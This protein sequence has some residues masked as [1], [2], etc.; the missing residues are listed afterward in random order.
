M[1][2]NFQTRNFESAPGVG[3]ALNSEPGTPNSVYP[4]LP[5]NTESRV[6]ASVDRTE[7]DNMK[8][9]LLILGMSAVFLIGVSFSVRAQ[10]IDT[11]DANIP[12]SF[13]V[14]NTTVPAGTYT[15]TRL[16]SA[17]NVMLIRDQEGHAAAIFLA[18]D[19]VVTKE[20]RETE[21]IFNRIGD[22]YFLSKIFE[23]GSKTGV[24][25]PKPR[26]ERDLEKEALTVRVESVSVH[27]AL[28]AKR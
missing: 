19:A 6:R 27:A 22:T 9:Y 13:T 2:P 18:K 21:L 20:P 14:N 16:D 7:G 15:I 5:A 25:L 12:F 23:E 10:I 8:K 11:I 4:D 3:V 1:S 26:A 24:V 28:N 17:P